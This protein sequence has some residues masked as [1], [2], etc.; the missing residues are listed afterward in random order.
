MKIISHRGF[1]HTQSEKNTKSAFCR[2]F[3]LGFGTETD[4]RDCMGDLVISHDLPSGEEITLTTLLTLT[5]EDQKLLAI[6]VKADGLAKL[7]SETMLDYRR[8]NWFVFDMSIPDMRAHLA[9]GNPVFARMSEVELNPVWLD[10]VEGVWLDSFDNNWFN[11]TIIKNLIKK[12]KRV[13]VVSSELHGRDQFDLWSMLLP[14]AE[15]DQLI[16]CTDFPLMAKE[17]FEV[18]PKK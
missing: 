3:E 17:Y 6:N 15:V 18:L 9:V 14:M 7:L 2:S 16:L 13:C 4:V 1:W 12:G 10:R 8:A 5:G 11:L